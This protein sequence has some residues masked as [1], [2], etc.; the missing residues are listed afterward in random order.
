[1]AK[2]MCND[3][4]R[5]RDLAWTLDLSRIDILYRHYSD[6]NDPSRQCVQL[7]GERLVLSKN[8]LD[9]HYCTPDKKRKNFLLRR[10]YVKGQEKKYILRCCRMSNDYKSETKTEIR[11]KKSKVGLMCV[12]LSHILMIMDKD[13]MNQSIQLQNAHFRGLVLI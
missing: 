1:M 7:R 12:T 11:D 2:C 4:K 6:N 5:P 3:E 13:R 9:A 8:D 10:V